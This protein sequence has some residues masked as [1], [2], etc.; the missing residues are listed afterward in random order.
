MIKVFDS[1]K[2]AA[3]GVVADLKAQIGTFKPKLLIYFAS[4]IYDPVAI[5]SLMKQSFPSSKLIGCTTAGEIVSGKMLT[6]SVVAMGIGDD[7]VEDVAVEVLEGIKT[8]LNVQEAYSALSGH[9]KASEQ[10]LQ[11]HEYIGIILIDGLSGAEERLMEKIGDLTDLT[12]IGGSAGD[13]LKFAKTHVFHDGKAQSDAAVLAL[14][15][16]KRGYDTI[17]TQSFVTTG[18][19][20][21]A[22]DVDE[23]TRRVMSFNH[24]PAVAAYAQLVGVPEEK[25]ADQFMSHPLGL[26]MGTEPYI[27]SPQRLEGKDFVFYCNV[28][29]GMELELMSATDIVGDTRKAVMDK[30]RQLGSIAGIIDFHCILRTLELR[31]KKLTD[32]YGAIFTDIPTVGF[33]TYGEE[34]IGHINQ[35][36]TML[37][38]K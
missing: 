37:V 3:E 18:R 31:E 1:K 33:S 14:L 30:Q 36:S 38:F 7:V 27:R 19:K 12:F 21:V 9:F 6:E 16:L 29:K 34:Y 20:L 23:A 5:A 17:K 28:K 15:K 35:T 13:N 8:T 22:T 10:P 4:P 2:S 32:L 26:M 24:Q 25:A 11:M